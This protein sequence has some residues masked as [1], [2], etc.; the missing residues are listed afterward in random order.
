MK[1]I[2]AIMMIF[3]FTFNIL[4]IS[5]FANNETE[6]NMVDSQTNAEMQN[7]LEEKKSYTLDELQIEK[8]EAQNQINESNA[9]IGLI[10]EQLTELMIEVET[11]GLKI[12]EKQQEIMVLEVQEMQLL[13]YIEKTE[14]ELQVASEKYEKQ[15]KLLEDRLVVMY[16][17]GKTTY[18]DV[19]LRSESLT[20]FLSNYFLIEEITQTDS[21]LLNQMLIQKTS[22]EQTQA[23]L[24]AKKD[25]LSAARE[26]REKTA[27]ALSN[28][29][30]IKNSYMN[31]L[32]AKEME[33]HQEIE[34]YQNRIIEIEK[35]IM[36]LATQSIGEDYVGGIM[37]WPV[38]GYTYITSQ[39][40][41]RV[42]PVTGIYKLHTG[43][44]IRAPIGANFIAANDGVVV[45]AGWNNAYGKMVMIDHG[46]GVMTLYAHGSEICVE[47]GQVVKRGEIIL[48][49]GSTGYSTGPHAHFEV[50]INGQYVNPLDYITSYNN[51]NTQNSNTEKNEQEVQTVVLN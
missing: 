1:K 51:T 14:A 20:K 19:L 50:R 7:I 24:E 29:N 13:S 27:I 11:L 36:M 18:L 3:V 35:E 22:I 45:K 15:K 12:N 5:S 37:A 30:I 38:P 46:G 16:E 6:D 4:S 41:M 8:N 33:I 17:S 32:S 28:M 10:N 9:E 31:Q 34:E 2:I 42:H 25:E 47:L 26:S 23:E 40:G 39:F 49:V 48:K 43:T 21:E 44:D